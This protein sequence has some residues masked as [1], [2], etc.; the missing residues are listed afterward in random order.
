MNANA[1]LETARTM[2]ASRTTQSLCEMYEQSNTCPDK[3]VAM[4]RGWID[5]ELEARSPEAF[6]RWM[7]CDDPALMYQPSYF[8]LTA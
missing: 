4:M 7:D 3:N 8:F 2:I 5:E 6:E 1:L